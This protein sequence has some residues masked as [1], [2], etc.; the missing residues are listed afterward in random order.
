[1]IDDKP[2]WVR[3]HKALA[4]E[5]ERGFT[6]LVGKQYRFSE[7]L[8][9][10]LGKPQTSLPPDERRRWQ[11]M[12][13]QFASY[14]QLTIEERQHLVAAARRYLHQQ[15]DRGMGI[16][17][18]E[19]IQSKTKNQKSKIAT[20]SIQSNSV[21][22][23]RRIA[24]SL[25]QPLRELAEVGPKKGGYLTRL[26]L[27]TVRD[28]LFYYPRDHIDYARQVNIRELE[29]GET[30]T[31]V[32]KVHR[33]NCFSSPRNPKLTILELVLKDQSGQIKI[34]RFFA[35]SRYS[36]R[37]WQ[38]QQKRRYPVGA[39]IAASGLVKEHKYS[40]TL[41]DPELEVLAHPGDPID[42]LT[43]GRVVP[44]YALTEGVGADMVRQAV[45]AALPAITQLQDPLPVA[46]RSH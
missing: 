13:A 45:I 19:E 27:H 16:R 2:D 3:L 43:I 33:C 24:P 1:M 40:L 25:D 5:A 17:G 15:R 6:D 34:S 42:S 18:D 29:S 9:L 30:V 36:N 46:L 39:M 35:G 21:E 8:S 7:F 37:G 28:V 11:E 23:A 12:A 44:I 14:P 26:G 41:E 20:P 38:E 4:V 31:I 32:A 10:S 22:V